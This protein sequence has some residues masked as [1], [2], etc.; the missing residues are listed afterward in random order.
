[1]RKIS[2]RDEANTYYKTVSKA[3]NDFASETKSK[4]SEMYKYL[5]NNKKTFLKRLELD[6]VVGI[7]NVLNDVLSHKKHL[8]DDQIINFESFSQMFENTIV[9]KSPNVEYEKVL[10][11][12]FNTSLGHIDL[13]D[14]QNHIFK[15]NDFGKEVYSVIIDDS[16]MSDIEKSMIKSISEDI[17]SK[18][19]SISECNTIPFSPMK[20]W[21]SD[22]IELDRLDEVVKS[23]ISSDLVFDYFSKSVTVKLPNDNSGE[24]QYSSFKNYH[25]W[26]V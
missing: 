21:L 19:I 4:P 11:D 13:V 15:I 20:F 3:V 5:S 16:E 14:S 22:F 25:I 23:K 9:L 26:H 18:V 1:M 8:E 7:E 24:V 10:A 12:F 6:D 2:N 17:V